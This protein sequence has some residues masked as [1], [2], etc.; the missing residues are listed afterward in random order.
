MDTRES[1][2]AWWIAGILLVLLIIV[3][4]LWLSSRQSLPTVLENGKTAIAAERDQIAADCQG[5]NMNQEACKRDLA[6]LSSILAEFSANIEA[7]SSSAT[8][9]GTMQY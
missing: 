8:T 1:N 3:G 9:T 5:Q 6:D 4:Y 7:A 2:L